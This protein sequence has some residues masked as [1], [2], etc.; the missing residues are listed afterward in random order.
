MI[1]AGDKVDCERHAVPE[2]RSVP[3]VLLS[4]TLAPL[5]LRVE[6]G[7]AGV[8]SLRQVVQHASWS[9]G[10]KILAPAPRPQYKCTQYYCESNKKLDYHRSMSC[11]T[12]ILKGFSIIVK[13]NWH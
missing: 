3:R 1:A 13:D 11:R 7:E 10:R 6:V 4:A 2:D 9:H 8:A 12:N 5:R